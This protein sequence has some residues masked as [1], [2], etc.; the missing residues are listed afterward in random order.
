VITVQQTQSDAT[1]NH[2]M[3]VAVAFALVAAAAYLPIGFNLLAVGDL[4]TAEARPGCA[5]A[6]ARVI[7]GARL[8][9]F[10]QSG[11]YPFVAQPEQFAG[12]L[13]RF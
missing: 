10:R 11:H 9:V 6:L 13:R 8:A 12:L 3:W 2:V 7:P 5:R 4:Q 1:G